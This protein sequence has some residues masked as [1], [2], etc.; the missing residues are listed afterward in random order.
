MKPALMIMDPH[1]LWPYAG[2]VGGLVLFAL[3]LFTRIKTKASLSW[4]KTSG[5]VLESSIKTDGSQGV[6]VVCPNVVYEYTV[7]GKTYRSSQLALEESDINDSNDARQ[8][9]EQHPVGQQVDV[10]YNPKNPKDA[11]L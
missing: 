1:A 5:L 4:P 10:Y 6:R 9:A 3:G 2:I 8:R 11:V 7:A